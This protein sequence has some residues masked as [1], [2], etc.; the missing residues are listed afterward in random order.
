MESAD[1]V[2]MRSLCLVVPK[3][4]GEKVRKMLLNKGILRTELEIGKDKD[5]LLIPVSEHIDLDYDI[6]EM[7]FKER[8]KSISDYRALLEVPDG[9]RE[10]LP[11]SMDIVGDIAIVRLPGELK[12]HKTDIGVAIAKAHR[13]KT[14]ALDSGVE[15]DLRL[16]ELE[17]VFGS[18]TET[19]HKEFG[20]TYELDVAKV[21]FSPR[22]STE[23]R[24]IA[25]LVKKDETVID[26]FCGV[27]PFSIMIAKFATPVRV[28]AIDIN[29][30]AIRFLNRNIVRNRVDR[31]VSILGDAK[32]ILKSLDE[33]DRIIM[34]LPLSSFR[35]FDSAL[36]V[37]KDGGIIH[38][39]EI[40]NRDG[41]KDRIE[42]LE[43][44]A[45]SMGKGLSIELREVRA[46]SS[47][48]AH[49]AFDVSVQ[50]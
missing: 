29:P 45:A 8:E 28:Y 18:E 38:Y 32:E 30:E 48:K 27:G 2:R 15:G 3:M 20:L 7:E 46:Y 11:S 31:I 9:L 16:R 36:S 49:F 17:L 14:V 47:T 39:Y 42:D 10:F 23:R 19:V 41:A 50:G 24:R 34:N 1:S 6:K 37:I 5:V 25:D 43:R 21:Y 4:E 22:L 40:L 26:M 33:A 35:F 13:A 44:I 12:D